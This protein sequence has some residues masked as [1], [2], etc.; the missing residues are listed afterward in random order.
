MKQP[1]PPKICLLFLL[2]LLGDGLSESRVVVGGGDGGERYPCSLHVTIVTKWVESE[3]L[4]LE[5]TKCT[6]RERENPVYTRSALAHSLSLS[7]S[8]G[9]RS[10]TPWQREG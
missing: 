3:L 9:T 2:L 7:L 4:L 8:R 1:L 5:F 10:H 6:S